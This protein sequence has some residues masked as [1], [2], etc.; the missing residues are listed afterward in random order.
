MTTLDRGL[1][2]LEA[3]TLVVGG[4]IGAS[5]FLVPA[6]VAREVGTPG[7]LL[8]T[9]V[10]SGLL[11][12]CGALCF[13]ELSAAI[14]ET[15]GTYVFLRRAFPGTPVAFLFGWTMCFTYAAGAVAVVAAM[16]SIYT[17]E[18]L[19]PFISSGAWAP[20]VLAAGLI[21]ILTTV[22]YFGVRIGG[23]T[24]DA[25]TLLKVAM[26]LGVIV[27]GFA[28]GAEGGNQFTPFLPAEGAVTE[29][30]GSLGSAML[31]T[32][33]A[34]SGA[35]FVTHVA[36][37]VRDPARTVPRSILIAMAVV[38]AL[39]VGSNL[40]YLR[41]LSF[42]AL[43]ASERVAADAMEAILGP[44]GASVTAVAVLCSALG[45][46]NAQLLSYP[47]IFFAQSR[48]GLFFPVLARIHPV[49]RTPG[50]A[51]LLVGG[52]AVVYSLAGTY[53]QIL[54]AVGF[55]I[56]LLLS[57]TVVAVM[58][59]RV[60]EPALPRPYRVWGYPVT[61]VLF[62]V[63]STWYL[64]TLLFTRTVPSLAGLAVAL[65]GLPFYYRQRRRTADGSRG[66]SGSSGE[67]LER[68]G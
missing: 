67:H 52:L 57:L 32:L 19:G 12:L 14:P 29:A 37:E 44:V 35:Y 60:R 18:L 22:N 55:V 3:T 41:V 68:P 15:G 17:G 38:L 51:I 46:L 9:W 62:L 65:A 7:L 10:L 64:A 5:I 50:P 43:Q 2:Q 45:T 8:V 58:V 39:Y 40:A 6:D 61:P 20:R 53:Q 54:N 1:G 66:R 49:H 42:D 26:L 48:D 24:Q 33:F 16:A 34:F 56:Q 4:I 11:A 25:L 47:R 31:L 63:I 13:A 59:L 27:L 30:S 28:F 21:G 23:K 36:G